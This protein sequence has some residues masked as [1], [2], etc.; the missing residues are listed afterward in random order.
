M[1]NSSSTPG[2][3][4]NSNNSAPERS[5]KKISCGLP[6]LLR[7][8][9]FIADSGCVIISF[10]LRFALPYYTH[11]EDAPLFGLPVAHKDLVETKGIRTT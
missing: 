2:R 4:N 8:S 7:C 1:A 11:L 3:A 10:A 5:Q 6:R 9:S